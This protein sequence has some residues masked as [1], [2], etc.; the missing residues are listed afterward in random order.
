MSTAPKRLR[1]ETILSSIPYSYGLI[2]DEDGAE[3]RVF[4]GFQI[5]KSPLGGGH[6]TKKLELSGGLVREWAALLGSSRE[7]VAEKRP[8]PDA[9]MSRKPE[10]IR[11]PTRPGG[12]DS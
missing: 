11:R 1:D 8:A 6:G 9:Q 2:D 7:A 12:A 5:Q 4:F 10:F 3:N